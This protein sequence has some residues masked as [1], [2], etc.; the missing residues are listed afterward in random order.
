LLSFIGGPLSS[1]RKKKKGRKKVRGKV[2]C[3]VEGTPE[4]GPSYQPTISSSLSFSILLPFFFAKTSW[5]IQQKLEQ[6]IFPFL[7][8]FFINIFI[9]TIEEGRG[10][11]SKTYRLGVK[12]PYVLILAMTSPCFPL[13]SCNLSKLSN[14]KRLCD[15][16]S[17]PIGHH[18]TLSLEKKN[19]C[20]AGHAFPMLVYSA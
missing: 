1:E 12:T 2:A 16:T 17:S 15:S 10:L 8:K 4:E 19:Q 13:P 5:F 6:K 9:K 3:W 7:Q 14:G 20:W 18:S 11:I